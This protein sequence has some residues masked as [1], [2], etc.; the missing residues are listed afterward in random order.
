MHIRPALPADIAQLIAVEQ[1]AAHAFLR[2]PELAWLANAEGLD[3]MAHK[4]FIDDHGSWLAEDDHGQVLGFV[5]M[6]LERQALHVHE[7]SVRL[8]LQG[9]G[10]GRQLLDQACAVAR[11]RGVLTLTLTTFAQVAWNG[12]FYARYGFE[13]LNDQQLDARLQGILAT[14]RA[15]GLS[16]RCAMRLA[17]A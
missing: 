15:H 16:G 11:D 2:L 13:V 3:E 10:I 5:C 6:S 14:E 4:A 17:L 8:Q 12:P 1:S 7:L 9:Q